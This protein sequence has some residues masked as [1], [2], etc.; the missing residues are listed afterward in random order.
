MNRGVAMLATGALAIA[1]ACSGVECARRE[2]VVV[3]GSDT[4]LVLNRRLAEAFMAT[5]PGVLVD[6]RGGGSGEGVEALIDG[7]ADLCAASRPLTADE[8]RRLYERHRSL[9]L[10]FLVAQDAL[11]VYVHPANPVHDLTLEELRRVFSGTAR[12]WSDVG[13]S[14]LGI[15]VVVRPPSSGTHRFFRDHVLGGGEYATGAATVPT[16]RGVV[17][18]VASSPAAVGYG[19][20]AYA[21]GGAVRPLHVDGAEPTIGTVRSGRYPLARYLQL[22]AVEQPRGNVA[23]FVDFCLGAVGQAIVAEVGYVPMWPSRAP[24]M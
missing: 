13:G 1:F 9:G 18:A 17:R 16:T 4:M 8:I 11:T 20:I 21:A 22:Y 12:R 10:R 2:P 14:A 19:G 6:V 3:A 24:Q 23:A 7:R 5:T 15:E